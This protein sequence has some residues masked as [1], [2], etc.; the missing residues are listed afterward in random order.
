MA[1]NLNAT[2]DAL[3]VRLATIS[4]LRVYDYPPDTIAEPAGVIA[5]PESVEY[6]QTY[7][8]GAD[9]ATFP[10]HVLTGKVSDR[11]SRDRIGAYVART[12]GSSVK[13]TLEAEP[14]LGGVV[15]SLRVE[16]ATFSTMA[17]AGLEYL[18]PTFD[19]EVYA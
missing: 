12:G 4:G 13:T 17:V 1:L 3:G 18:A 16:R 9:R 6:D 2:M 5:Y 19:V 15:D 11:A 10:V 14:T 8:G 7:A